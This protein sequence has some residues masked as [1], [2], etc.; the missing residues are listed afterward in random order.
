MANIADQTKSA[1]VN[2]FTGGINTDLHPMLQPNN[3][4]TDCV[5]GTLITYN[6]N[7]NMLQNDMGNYALKG[8]KLPVN[9]VPIGVKEYGGILYV[10]AYNPIDKKTQ[11]GSY[12]S[13]KVTFDSAKTEEHSITVSPYNIKQIGENEEFDPWLTIEEETFDSTRSAQEAYHLHSNVVK[14]TSNLLEILGDLKDDSFQLTINDQYKLSLTIDEDQ[15]DPWMQT[16]KYFCITIDG[17]IEDITEKIVSDSVEFSNVTW[18]SAGWV[19]IKYELADVLKNKQ[20]INNVVYPTYGR[21]T[22]TLWTSEETDGVLIA[23]GDLSQDYN[24]YENPYVMIP[25]GDNVMKCYWEDKIPE[26]N[27]TVVYYSNRE[28]EVIDSTLEP[29]I[30]HDGN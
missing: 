5:N 9:Y 29:N 22:N 23:T 21:T 30:S 4:L 10:V 28:W 11:I 13:P 25:D 24:Y 12:P 6:G 18:E 15:V 17:K 27:D 7:E 19:G 14:S 8:A 1:Q 2:S 20:S 16:L 3:T 26:N